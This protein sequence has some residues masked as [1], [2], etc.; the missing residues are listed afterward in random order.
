MTRASGRR[1]PDRTEALVITGV[2]L[3]LVALG[4]GALT[5]IVLLDGGGPGATLVVVGTGL[6]SLL[7]VLLVGVVWRDILAC[8]ASLYRGDRT[9]HLRHLPYPGALALG[10][11][12]LVI[13]SLAMLLAVLS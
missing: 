4:V 5:M 9:R 8:L 3:Q 2:I 6:W 11:G 13:T 7:G 1:L 12:T 10:S